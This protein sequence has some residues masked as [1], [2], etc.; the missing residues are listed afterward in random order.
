MLLNMNLTGIFKCGFSFAA[1]C[2]LVGKTMGEM[3]EDRHAETSRL[4]GEIDRLAQTGGGRVVVTRGIHPCGT[5]YLKS[6]VE[7]HL[8][9]GAVLLGSES[10][11]DYDDAIPP[12]EVYA[13]ANNHTNTV[14]RKA[15]VYAENAT[16]VAIT[17]R[18]VIEG[19]GPKF[20][21]RNTVLWERF[22][23]KPPCMRPRM[24]VFMNCRGV[25]FAET[26]F[27]DCPVWTMWLRRCEDVVISR[28]R[29]E[30][31]PHMINSDG[32]DFDACRNVRVG[33]SAFS[34]GDD[35]LVLRAIRHAGDLDEA[36]TENV[37][38]SNCVLSTP[39]QGVRI[40][41]PSDHVIR[42]AVFRDMTFTGNNAIFA[43]QQHCYLEEGNAGNVTTSNLLFENWKIS[44]F[45]H[46]ISIL[47][48]D[49]VTLGDFGHM[50]FRNIE[51]CASKSIRVCGNETTVVR[52]VLLE[53]VRGIIRATPPFEESRTEGVRTIG[54]DLRTR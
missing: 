32:I 21:D 35:C 17:G 20:F 50:T 38:V 23:A 47:V 34:T 39:C 42:N 48:T 2:L 44:C 11:E 41:C 8:E 31:D 4:Q 43:D 29:I 1:V 33:D 9:E 7:L 13:Y 27:R 15:F 19:Q 18:G 30:A 14:T 16:N 53:G 52:D 12:R 6:N 37:V 49:G 5:L 3:T 26:T 46:P 36:V 40:A 51:V 22:W 24:V 28:I 54:L 45:G 25:R 10:P